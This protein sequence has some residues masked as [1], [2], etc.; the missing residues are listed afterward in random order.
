MPET[1]KSYRK[2]NGLLKYISTVH[3]TPRLS[4]NFPSTVSTLIWAV[5]KAK[6]IP[7][8]DIYFMG[9]WIYS[10]TYQRMYVLAQENL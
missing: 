3:V 7:F 4:G 5:T 2:I 9:I 10:D 8:Q 6:N 1:E